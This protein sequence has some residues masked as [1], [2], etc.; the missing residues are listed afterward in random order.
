MAEL[1]GS[2]ISALHEAGPEIAK[3][4]RSPV[5]D[6][7]AAMIRAGAGLESI[8]LA[9]VN[10]LVQYSVRR[11]LISPNEGERLI[12]EIRATGKG[13]SRG[14]KNKKIKTATKKVS[15][16]KTPAKKALRPKKRKATKRR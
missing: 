10:E 1:G 8:R 5:A 15:K 6:S 2:Q 12:A 9:D 16:S 13:R 7:L 4:L 11:G 14:S 3:V